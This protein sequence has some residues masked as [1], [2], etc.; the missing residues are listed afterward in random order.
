M[1]SFNDRFGI[2][3]VSAESVVISRKFT[4]TSV[5]DNCTLSSVMKAMHVVSANSMLVISVQIVVD[6]NDV[7]Q[8]VVLFVHEIVYPP[9][10]TLV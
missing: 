2:A 1:R 3:A 10:E 5:E 4:F 6:Y 7:F 9:D 8:P